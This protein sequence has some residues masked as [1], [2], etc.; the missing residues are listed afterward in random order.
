MRIEIR[1]GAGVGPT[2][3][4]AFDTALH[5]AGVAN[6]NLL[7]LSSVIPPKSEISLPD[8]ARPL[9]VTG[10]WGDRLYVVMAE[11]RT[12]TPGTEIWSGVGWVQDI[13]TG[14]GLF[15]EHCGPSESHVR[16]EI[17]ASLA[18]LAK[19]RHRDLGEVHML[20]KGTVCH[21]MPACALV[22]A[23]YEAEAWSS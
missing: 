6:F 23:V 5:D 22:V 13:E 20:L 7:H 8:N 21:D 18:T 1:A 10:K 15:V 12:S 19:T 9:A 17:N 16:N 4:A 3:L 14:E 2:E 11:N